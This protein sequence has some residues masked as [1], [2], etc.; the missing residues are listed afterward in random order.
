M[1]A[2]A[3]TRNGFFGNHQVAFMLKCVPILPRFGIMHFCRFSVFWFLR[4]KE[5]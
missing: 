2:K 3:C 4:L 1:E 5:T